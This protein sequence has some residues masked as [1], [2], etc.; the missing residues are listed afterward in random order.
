LTT[1]ASE[2]D[3]AGVLNTGAAEVL[4]INIS[5]PGNEVDLDVFSPQQFVVIGSAY[6]PGVNA[7]L[8]GDT[9]NQ[10]VTMLQMESLDEEDL[11]QG[12]STYGVFFEQTD[13][14][15]N[16]ADDLTIEYPLSQR[17]AD[18]FV[19]IGE[20]QTSRV[21]GAS[22]GAVVLN[23]INVGAAK[24]ASEIR[25]QEMSMNMIV[26]GG[27][28]INTA[29][30][31][32]MGSDSALCGEASGLS[33]GQAVIKLFE[34]NGY[35]AMLVAG[36]DKADTRRACKVVAEYEDWAD[37]F[38]GDELV[39]S[40]TSMADIDVATPTTSFMAGLGAAEEVA[41]EEAEEEVME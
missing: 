25:G 23:P 12:L 11:R 28:C 2:F 30:A 29:A 21:G 8:Y 3:G 41:E 5:T 6:G 40:G 26:V 33:A 31:K 32:L 36:Y 1:L 15:G 37:K 27:P 14:T 19:V 7:G 24:L 38:V 13:E 4:W 34:N 20:T 22:G 35:V 16:D 17:G 18:V 39:V 10:T 9:E